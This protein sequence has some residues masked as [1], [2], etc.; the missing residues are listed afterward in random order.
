MLDDIHDLPIEEKVRLVEKL[1]DDIF[2]SSEPFPLRPWHE[3]EARKRA[4]E[5]DANPSRA[6]DRAELWRKV[7]SINAK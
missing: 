1:W 2:A 4:D 3:E 5:L 7:R 6:I